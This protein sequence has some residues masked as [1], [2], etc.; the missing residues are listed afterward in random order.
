MSKKSERPAPVRERVE[1]ERPAKP[2]RQ[3]ANAKENLKTKAADRRAPTTAA[4]N[5]KKGK[6]TRKAVLFKRER[7]WISYLLSLLQKDRGKIPENIG[8]RI[9]MTN[10]MYITKLYLSSIIQIVELG[11]N[12]PITFFQVITNC[13]RDE[14]SHAIIDFTL[15]NEH[16]VI[17]VHESGLQS[18]K[19]MWEKTLN[20]PQMTNRE[21]ERATRCL[22]TY[23]VAESGEQLFKSRIILTIRAKTGSELVSAEKKVQ[24]IL[25]Q[26][27]ATFAPV[28]SNL[29]EMMT[30]TSV[31]SGRKDKKIK[32]IAPIINSCKTMSQLLP[33][34]GS[35]NSKTDKMYWG[36]DIL[37]GTPFLFD[38]VESTTGRNV[39]VVA[40]TGVGKTVLVQNICASAL[41][42]GHALCV[43]DIKGNEFPNLINSVGG[44]I[45]SLRQTSNECINTFKMHSKDTTYDRAES[46]FNN[47]ITFSKSQLVTLSGLTDRSDRETIE[48]FL[49][50][51]LDSLYIS[52]GVTPSNM[53]SWVNT[54]DLTFYDVYDA[55]FSYC[56]ESVYKKHGQP[57]VS[58]MRRW[59]VYISRNGTKSYVVRR[60]FD[61]AAILNAK[62]IMFDFGLLQGNLGVDDDPCII[63]L[64][65]KYMQQLNGEF[66][67]RKFAE[68]IDTIKVLEESQIV[69]DDILRIYAEEYTLRRAQ[70]QPPFMLGNSVQALTKNTLSGPMLENTK[71]LL[72]GKLEEESIRVLVDR[73]GLND[74]E[75]IIRSVGKT[76][77]SKNSFLFINR[78]DSNPIMP[79]LKIIINGKDKPLIMTSVAEKSSI[80]E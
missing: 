66:I 6:S 57:L 14:N 35:Y 30:Y 25:T 78:V 12:T 13:L 31:I 59:K 72:V 71:Y 10:N 62:S 22:Y 7:M 44:H 11:H 43:M 17:N 58:A 26:M 55:L 64:K 80:A 67:T 29:K 23:G 45:I 74:L 51:F 48:S 54:Q 53:N 24:E 18:R 39:Y 28:T 5:L 56:R 63:D 16:F 9:L 19:A 69:S 37:N 4:E 65:F 60:E 32:D 36:N 79:M 8:N 38:I 61:Y 20:E 15:L 75:H 33:N 50:D 70:R 77:K 68:G 47:R 41:E 49:D 46:Y 73:F 21:K 2:A 40:P 1:R 76:E 3:R 42:A 52:R 34:T 27:G